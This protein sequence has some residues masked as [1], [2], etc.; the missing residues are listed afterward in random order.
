MSDFLEEFKPQNPSAIEWHDGTD[1]ESDDGLGGG[2]GGEAGGFD[3]GATFGNDA[4]A[5]FGSAGG[6]DGEGF[7]AD[8]DNKVAS[9]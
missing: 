3:V 1:D 9:W 4:A 7:S 6:F 2:F 5:G 8:A